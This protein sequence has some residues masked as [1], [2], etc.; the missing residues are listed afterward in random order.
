MLCALS[1]KGCCFEPNKLLTALFKRTFSKE[2]AEG[3]VVLVEA[4]AWNQEAILKFSIPDGFNST[5]AR[6]L[7]QESK[8]FRQRRSIRVVSVLGLSR[9]DFIKMELKAANSGAGGAR[10]TLIRS[11]PNCRGCRAQPGTPHQDTRRYSFHRSRLFI[12]DPK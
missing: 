1:P 9:V 7:K 5:A 3:R 12:H 11:S 2:I 10:Q 8:M 4:A 6:L